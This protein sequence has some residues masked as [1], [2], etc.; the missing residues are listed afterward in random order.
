MLLKK[1]LFVF[2]VLLLVSY[3]NISEF[4]L[5][6]NVVINLKHELFDDEFYLDSDFY[7]TSI[8]IG[9]FNNHPKYTQYLKENYKGIPKNDSVS[10]YGCIDDR[11]LYEDFYKLNDL[12]KEN[13]EWYLTHKDIDTLNLSKVKL[14]STIIIVIG[15][16]KNKQF[17][18]ADTN[19][20]KDFS[21]D[22]KYEYDIN[23]RNHFEDNIKQL[24]SMPISE[25]SYEDCYNGNIQQYDRKFILYPDRNNR[26]SIS[27]AINPKKEREYFSILKIRDYWQG[28]FVIDNIK[29]DFIYHGYSNHY[30]LLIVKPSNISYE[31]S[32]TFESN[33]F[34]KYYGKNQNN[35][36][37][38]I[39]KGKYLI[40]SIS[41][42]ISKLYLRKVG[43][44]KHFGYRVGN[45]INDIDLKDLKNKEFKLSSIIDEKKYT[46]IEFWGTWCGP[47][48]AM[49]PKVKELNKKYSKKLNIV[50]IAVDDNKKKVENYIEKHGL[51]WKMAH[52][53]K[54]ESWNNNIIKKLKIDFYPSFILID[55]TGQIISR[56]EP[57][58]LE[59]ILEK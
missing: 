14:K 1:I 37:I 16:N 51:N 24:N 12:T 35:D 20:N 25:Y 17:L 21:D 49:T 58:A 32:A 50:G 39:G 27:D 15:F 53:P 19:R 18:I 34:F 22:I 2:T 3:E 8:K 4:T 28:E 6:D 55:S 26:F 5:R 54:N 48:V 33:Y 52:I 10:Y 45:Y 38:C 57:E 42:N 11:F 40:D 41:R 59:K 44:Q 7:Y 9:S 23:F 30:G 46:L 47:C 31:N 43:V 56:D 36:T 13:T 29:T